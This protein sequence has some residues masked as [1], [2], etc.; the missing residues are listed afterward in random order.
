M[1]LFICDFSSLAKAT[2]SEQDI[3]K[4]CSVAENPG[5]C[6]IFIRE[7]PNFETAGIVDISKFVSPE[8]RKFIG[9]TINALYSH[10][11]SPKVD[12]KLKE[13]YTICHNDL[14]EASR[15]LDV[16]IK[17]NSFTYASMNGIIPF[18]NNKVNHCKIFLGDYPVLNRGYYKR[19]TYRVDILVGIIPV[20]PRS[21][22]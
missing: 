9:I 15:Q 2:I 6:N 14:V 7:T 3:K 1:T 8:A 5:F 19:I 4:I 22:H 16:L 20:S 10:I 21:Q 13:K 11:I 17:N 18:V 12:K